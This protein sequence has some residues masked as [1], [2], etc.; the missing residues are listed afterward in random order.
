VFTIANLTRETFV[1]S[2]WIDPEVHISR[3]TAAKLTAAG[4]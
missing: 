2:S 4:E 1:G 3:P